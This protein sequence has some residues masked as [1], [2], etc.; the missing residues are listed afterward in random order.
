[1]NI[2]I[3]NNQS[4]IRIRNNI[5]NTIVRDTKDPNLT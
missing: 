2:E 1:M 5:Q 3:R 4:E